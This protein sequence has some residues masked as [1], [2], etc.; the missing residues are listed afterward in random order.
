M[1]ILGPNCPNNNLVHILEKVRSCSEFMETELYILSE[2]LFFKVRKT[3]FKP[4]SAK[5]GVVKY[6]GIPFH[7]GLDM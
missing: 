2:K 7:N 4:Q 1:R 5:I 3:K 6:L